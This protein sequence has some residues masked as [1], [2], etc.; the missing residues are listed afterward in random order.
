MRRARVIAA[1]RAPDRLPIR[2]AKGDTVTL[3][4]RDTDWPDFVWT[5]VAEGHGG[6]VPATLFEGQGHGPATA[7][8]DY[9][10][11]ELDADAGAILSLH[12]ALAGWWWAENDN[13]VQGWIPARNLQF[14]EENRA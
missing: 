14:I 12:H 11:R 7:L 3:G 8:H 13:G 4:E 1:H 9:D 2:V 5:A 10:T 6:W